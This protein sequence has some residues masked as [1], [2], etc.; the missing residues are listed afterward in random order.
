MKS[1]LCL[2]L[3]FTM[4]FGCIRE[5]LHNSYSSVSTISPTTT[6][7][8]RMHRST[9]KIVCQVS[10]DTTYT[11]TGW[12]VASSSGISYIVTAGHIVKDESSFMVGYWTG[13]GSW[14]FI[15]AN[16]LGKSVELNTINGDVALLVIP[17]ELPS[18]KLAKDINLRFDAKTRENYGDEVV[19]GGVH[20]QVAPVSVTLGAVIERMTYEFT[21]NSWATYGYS[22]GPVVLRRTNEVIG[23]ISRNGRHSNADMTFTICSDYVTI[24]QLL[25]AFN[26]NI[27]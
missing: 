12:V 3:V 19:V 1:V 27:D 14:N 10:A 24:R 21:I 25:S 7:V 9:V 18:L 23:L 6:L 5:H 20:D 2:V 26:I 13:H 16:L 17:I 8:D 11:G 4:V 15:P 22:G